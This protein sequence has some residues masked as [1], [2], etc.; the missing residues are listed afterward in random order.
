VHFNE[1]G[2]TFGATRGRHVYAKYMEV[3]LA[4]KKKMEW[5][6]STQG[7][8]RGGSHEEGAQG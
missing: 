5:H 6:M 8:A 2:L 4:I 7:A 1:L 3:L